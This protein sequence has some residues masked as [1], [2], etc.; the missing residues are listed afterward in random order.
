MPTV[1][2]PAVALFWATSLA[3]SRASVPAG[4]HRLI[5]ACAITSTIAAVVDEHA[6]EIREVTR[7]C[8]GVT[9]QPRVSATPADAG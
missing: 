5:L 7:L 1:R 9:Q 8:W 3:T 6:R 2:N 4:V